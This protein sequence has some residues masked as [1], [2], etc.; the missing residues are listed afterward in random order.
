M[1]S[2][3]RRELEA[4]DRVFQA[5]L[6]IDVIP[7]CAVVERWAAR[8]MLMV[9][10]G[11]SFSA[12]TFAADLHESFTGQLARPATPLEV[13]SMTQRDAGLACLSAGGRNQDIMLAFRTAAKRETQPLSALVLA[14][15]SPLEDIAKRF[16]YADIVCVAHCSFRD[17]YLAVASLIG[18]AVLLT[19]AYRKVFGRSEKEIPKDIAALIREATS[20]SNLGEVS[21]QGDRVIHDRTH[22]SVLYSPELVATA[23]DLESRFV[24]A[25]L[26][27]LHIADLRNFGH[28]RHYWMARRAQETVTLALLSETQND[29]GTRTLSLL[30]DEVASLP[31][32]FCGPRDVQAIAGLV[33]G[34]Y[35]AEC[36]ARAVKIDPGKPGVPP[37]GRKLYRLKPKEI[38]Q[39]QADLNLAAAVQRKG[40]HPADPQWVECYHHTLETINAARYQA[41][42][43]DYDGTLCETRSRAVGLSPSMAE[44]MT[45]L[46]NAGAFFGLATGRG[47]SAGTELRASISGS[48][49]DR[50]LV[51]YYNCA[52][53]RPLTD[54]QDP[55]VEPLDRNHPMLEPLAR[56]PMLSGTVR[57]NA[58]QISTAARPGVRAEDAGAEVRLLMRGNDVEGEVLISG[59]SVDVCLAG[60]SKDDL[61]PALREHFQLVDGPILR[62]GDRGK[63]PGNDWKLLD[64][65]HGLSVDEVSQH[66]A[67]CWSL[68]PA[69]MKG[70]QATEHYLR[71]LRWT[72]SGG[73]LRLGP[74]KRR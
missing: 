2:R 27:S 53:I 36:V 72:A 46:G 64:N 57:S 26:G 34:L 3:Y 10:S 54:R 65:V 50:V 4:L 68:V 71:R 42:V 33:V 23:V 45:R 14:E 67:H 11:G 25:A 60:Q 48:L 70:T 24:E 39:K 73:R 52:V 8:P 1:P 12:A 41:L 19:R 35:F 38:R 62:I 43:L 51:G 58:V 30:P 66:P 7:L 31:A 37:F 55:V 63:P 69:G 74:A 17:G 28:G 29:L 21:A 20:F 40:G 16:R 61:L 59:H 6:E 44:Q 13:I 22:V 32:F 56:H 15:G 47:P 49:H 5:A 18:T 9:G